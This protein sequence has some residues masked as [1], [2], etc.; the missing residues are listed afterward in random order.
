VATLRADFEAEE[1]LTQRLIQA[2]EQRQE[3]VRQDRLAQGL[4]RTVKGSDQ[5]S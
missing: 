5:G 3:A 2:S 4:R 1:G